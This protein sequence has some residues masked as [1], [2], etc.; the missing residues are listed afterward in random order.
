LENNAVKRIDAHHHLWRYNAE[1]FDWINDEMR[2]LR[3]DFLPDELRSGMAAA[4]VNGTVAVQARQSLDETQWL[5]A[6]AASAPGI[7]GIV[8]WLPIASPSLAQHLEEFSADPLLKGVRHVVQAEP[9]GFLDDHAFNRGISLLKNTGLVYDILIFPHQIEEAIRFVDRHPQQSFVLD[10]IAKPRIAAGEIDL[11]S[12]LIRELALRPHVAC[13]I[14]GM[15]TEA[16]WVKW[17]AA[18]LQPYF[19]VVLEA[20]GPQRLMIGTDWPV[21]TVACGYAQWW[22]TVEQWIAPLTDNER[23]QI[24]GGTAERVYKL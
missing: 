20:F 14:S 1:E 16:D 8:G 24:L 17:T 23:R 5:L 6:Q 11:W 12:A 10:H 9:L 21:L 22:N 3:R 19:E 2:V 7:L 15:V 18:Q 4:H 13:K